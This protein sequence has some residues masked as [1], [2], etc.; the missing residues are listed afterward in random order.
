M[1]RLIDPG[2]GLDN[3]G[4]S[5]QTLAKSYLYATWGWPAQIPLPAWFEVVFY[6]GTNPSI[7]G[8]YIVPIQ[9][10]QPTENHECQISVPIKT[11]L[12]GVNVAV[13]AVYA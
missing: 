8:T 7:P 3:N 11:A 5:P 6:I 10:V 2:D 9:K 13:R 12:T 4:G 1:S